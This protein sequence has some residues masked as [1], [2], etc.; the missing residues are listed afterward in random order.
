MDTRLLIVLIPVLAA[1][2]WALYNIGR[3][4]LQQFKKISS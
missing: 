1:A 2:S 3:I 4:L